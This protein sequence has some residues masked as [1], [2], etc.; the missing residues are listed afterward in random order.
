[1]KFIR[2]L[3]S[4]PFLVLIACS[5][6]LTYLVPPEGA[7][8][9]INWVLRYLVEYVPSLSMHVKASA[10]PELASVYFP[11]M[12]LISPL[13]FL[14]IWLLEDQKLYWKELFETKPV[15][16][17]FRLLLMIPFICAFAWGTFYVGGYQLDSL[18]WH[19]SKLVLA[20]LGYAPTGGVFWGGLAMFI[21]GLK[22][23]FK[24]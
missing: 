6:L 2:E 24:R 17:F 15:R 1:M 20:T 16:T 5:F 7:I 11:L 4:W 8:P 10:F 13:A 22:T 21:F 9:G 3:T 14:H 23:L 12:F 19:E 18:P